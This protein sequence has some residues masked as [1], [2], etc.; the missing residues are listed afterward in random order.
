M[1]KNIKKVKHGVENVVAMATC[2]THDANF[3]QNLVPQKVIVKV[4]I[5]GRYCLNIKEVSRM[6]KLA[7]ALF[8]PPPPPT[9][10]AE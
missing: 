8:A 7:W 1:E 5:F 2:D 6:L 3:F 10:Q 4:A 9:P